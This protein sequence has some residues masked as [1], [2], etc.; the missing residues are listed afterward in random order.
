MLMESSIP[1]QNPVVPKTPREAAVTKAHEKKHRMDCTSR[2]FWYARQDNTYALRQLLQKDPSL[3]NT[4]GYDGR[5]S[6][7]V[8]AFYNCL[9][10][11]TFLLRHGAHVNA[12]DRWGN[13]PLSDAQTEG[14]K[15]MVN[16]LKE[17][18]GQLLGS[19]G[20]KIRTIV[21]PVP[22]NCDWRVDPSELD[23]SK[24]MVIGKG[25]FGEI[26]K[27]TWRGTPVAVKKI[28]AS[29]SEDESI[30]KHFKE[31]VELL[32]KLRHP[33]VVQFLGATTSK[34]LMLV[35]E[36]LKAGDL[37]SFLK[38]KGAL[39]ILTVIRFAKDIARGMIYLHHGSCCI[40]HRDLKPRNLL[41]LEN[42][43]VKVADFGLSKIF[44][45]NTR[46]S[47]ILTGETGSYRYMAPEVFCHKPY[48][49]KVDVFSFA[50]ILYQM[51][52]GE[53]PLRELAPYEAAKS[54]AIEGCRPKLKSKAYPQQLKELIIKCWSRTKEKRPYFKEILTILEG[55]ELEYRSR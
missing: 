44:R 10:A 17:N 34:P 13:S 28:L 14:H 43:H 9:A 53:S 23:F 49:T 12:Q 51:I 15:E 5:T 20:I 2:F 46:Q 6:L 30:I 27:A 48:D 41:L 11:A 7:H 32:L 31:E 42:N 40:I 52:E 1:D 37:H 35:M 36:F 21:P 19:H 45:S 38:E 16:L 18:G 29:L 3:V 25:S 33:N 24:G 54:M 22:Q 26:W 47:Y 8:C 4:Y 55:I 50:M 39:P